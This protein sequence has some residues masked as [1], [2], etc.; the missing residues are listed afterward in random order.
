MIAKL[1]LKHPKPD[2]T[3]RASKRANGARRAWGE[4]NNREVGK[5]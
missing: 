2:G 4:Q 1:I 5:W 3:S